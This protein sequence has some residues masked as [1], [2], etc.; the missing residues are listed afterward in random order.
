MT[1]LISR[2]PLHL[3]PGLVSGFAILVFGLL[4]NVCYL[5]GP[6]VEATANILHAVF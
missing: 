5:L 1:R 4:A 3:R 2:L 6:V